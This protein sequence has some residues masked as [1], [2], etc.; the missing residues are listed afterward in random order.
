MRAVY[1]IFHALKLASLA[2]FQFGDMFLGLMM[3]LMELIWRWV[4]VSR[5]TDSD[6]F[7]FYGINDLCFVFPSYIYE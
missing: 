4:N 3:L 5:R 1:Q 7:Y 2:L 6:C